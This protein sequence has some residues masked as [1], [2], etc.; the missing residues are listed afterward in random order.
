MTYTWEQQERKNEVKAAFKKTPRLILCSTKNTFRGLT[1][2]PDI[3][4][5]FWRQQTA[6]RVEI[7]TFFF[8]LNA[9][10]MRTRKS[11]MQKFS[12]RFFPPVFIAWVYR[13]VNLARICFSL[14]AFF[15][16]NFALKHEDQ[17]FWNERGTC[18]FIIPISSDIVGSS[19][20]LLIFHFS[21]IF[22]LVFFF[23]VGNGRISTVGRKQK[24]AAIV[25]SCR[26]SD[27]EI[28]M[29]RRKKNW[30]D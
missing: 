26:F 2:P 19:L 1:K 10:R 28:R 13:H 30:T 16:S 21:L 11:L 9:S 25:Y 29:K 6:M 3:Q 17:I 27:D 15:F 22:C 4:Q 23:L 12:I 20:S 5:P 7:K 18:F 24:K 14:V 8:F